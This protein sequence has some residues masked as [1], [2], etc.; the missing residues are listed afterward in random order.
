MKTNNEIINICIASDNNFAPL[1]ATTIASICLNTTRRVKFWCLETNISDLNKHLIATLHQKFDNF[2]IEYISIEKQLLDN[3]AKKLF[4]FERISA[5]A[6]SRLFIPDLFPNLDKMI[7]LDVDIV[8]MGDIGNLYDIHLGDYA[9]GAIPEGEYAA[10]PKTWRSDMEIN[11]NHKYF[12]SGVLL[13]NPKKLHQE[14][15][16]DRL[17]QIANKYADYNYLELPWRFNMMGLVLERTLYTDDPQLREQINTEYKNIVIRHFESGCKPWVTDRFWIKNIKIKN[18]AEFWAVAAMTPYLTWFERQYQLKSADYAQNVIKSMLGTNISKSKISSVRLFG[19]L[20]LMRIRHHN[21]KT[22]FMLF[23]IIP[24]LSYKVK[25][26]GKKKVW[27][28]FDFITI[29]ITK[30]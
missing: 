28:L 9:I 5:D 17:A 25:N 19:F 2:E 29:F 8:A 13:M 20:P 21:K 18:S 24:I 23:N 16:L 22:Q 7:Y 4:V 30:Y 3:F 26:A 14:K 10:L 15:F 11:P 12:N 27:R 1:V 6:Y